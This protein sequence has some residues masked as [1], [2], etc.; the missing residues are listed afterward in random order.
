MNWF[1]YFAK[2]SHL[3]QRNYPDPAAGGMWSE[4]LDTE[5]RGLDVQY[6]GTYLGTETYLNFQVD[7]R[8]GSILGSNRT[9]KYESRVSRYVGCS[10]EV[11]FHLDLLKFGNL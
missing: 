6:L 5:R 4:N 9:R 2:S 1:Q 11:G 8:N 3:L 10:Q 7:Q